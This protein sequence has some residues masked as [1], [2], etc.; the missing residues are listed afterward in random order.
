MLQLVSKIIYSNIYNDPEQ[1]N[2]ESHQQPQA[3]QSIREGTL[4]LH[5]GG[6]ASF[7]WVKYVC[8]LITE[9]LLS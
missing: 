5:R 6:L 2:A 3:S 4:L 9:A 1:D 7:R 8:V